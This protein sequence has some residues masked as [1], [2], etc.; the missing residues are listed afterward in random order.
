V[1]ATAYTKKHFGDIFLD[2]KEKVVWGID[3]I[4][5]QSFNMDLNKID[6]TCEIIKQKAYIIFKGR[7][8]PTTGV[9][10]ILNK[11]SLGMKGKEELEQ[12]LKVNL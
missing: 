8:I 9:E 5:I 3:G 4:L 6:I 2:F 7:E 11:R 12:G 10:I 1:M